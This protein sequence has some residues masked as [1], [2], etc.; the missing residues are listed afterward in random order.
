MKGATTEEELKQ[1]E[2]AVDPGFLEE[3][4][5]RIDNTARA[6]ALVSNSILNLLYSVPMVRRVRIG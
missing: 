4:K 1:K 6:V 2:K 5:I 3:V